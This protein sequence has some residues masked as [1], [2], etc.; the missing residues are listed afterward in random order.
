MTSLSTS[1][2]RIRAF[3]DRVAMGRAAAADVAASLRDRLDRQSRVR[4]VFAAAPS[5]QELLDA[6]V[7]AP[8]VDWSR[9]TAFHMDEYLDLPTGAPQRFARWLCDAFFD[10]VPLGAV[11]LIEP[12]PDAEAT[13]REYAAALAAEPVDLVCLG[14][15]V[16]G[17]L[18]FNDPPVADLTDPL[19]VK[20]VQLDEVCRQQQVDDDCFATLADV[21]H[22]A[23]TLTVPRLL[24]AGRLFCV[25]PGQRKSTAVRRALTDPVSAECPATALRTHPDCTLYLDRE[26][27]AH[28]PPGVGRAG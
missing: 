27:A 28:L 25:V 9:V 12:G 22:R 19:D 3:D 5:Q 14:I 8:G 16:N 23:I 4:M 7:E 1:T 13:A 17:H 24:A 26:S 10:R 11:H 20:V 15:G 18:A 2:P 6:L 21:P